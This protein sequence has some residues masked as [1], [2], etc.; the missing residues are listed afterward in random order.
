ML[1]L[2][3][4]LF[5]I[6]AHTPG[7]P[8]P[9]AVWTDL[10]T[11][12]LRVRPHPEL[13]WWA[14]RGQLVESPGYMMNY[15]LGAFLAADLR[16]ELERRFGGLARGDTGWYARVADALFRPGAAE[17]AMAAV[18]RFLGRRPAPDALLADLGRIRRPGRR[19]RDRAPP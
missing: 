16:T 10:T 7:A 11:R 4:A 15:A 2:A 12:Y 3:W 5:E 8:S 18:E 17:P 1:D 19:R 9:N 6:R 13:S 14:M